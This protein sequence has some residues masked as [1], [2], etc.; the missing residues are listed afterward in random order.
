MTNIV[1][2]YRIS[3]VSQLEGHGLEA[4]QSRC[5]DYCRSKGYQVLEEFSDVYSGKGDY[6]ERPGF[7][8]MMEYIAANNVD[9]IVADDNK[10]ISRDLLGYLNL[11]KVLEKYNTRIECL[12]ANFE[13]T[14]EGRFV[15]NILAATAELEREQNRRQVINKMAERKKKGCWV[16]S[17]PFGFKIVNDA[18]HGKVLEPISSKYTRLI[19]KAFTFYSNDK[20]KTIR[21]VVNFLESNNLEKSNGGFL[22]YNAV[23]NMLSSIVY[24]GYNVVDGKKYKTVHSPIVSIELFEEVQSKLY[25]KG[26]IL[27]ERIQNARR[28]HKNLQDEYELSGVLKCYECHSNMYGR[29]AKKIYPYYQCTNK[30]CRIKNKCIGQKKSEY[31]A[32]L[33]LYIGDLSTSALIVHQK[34]TLELIIS[35]MAVEREK[36][37]AQIQEIEAKICMA[38]SPKVMGILEKKILELE[39]WIKE[40]NQLKNN[41]TLRKQ[42]WIKI[43]K[44]TKVASTLQQVYK[45]ANKKTR[46]KLLKWLFPHGVELKNGEVG[47]K[48]LVASKA[49]QG[50][51]KQQH[52]VAE[53]INFLLVDPSGLEPLTSCVQSRRS[54]Q[55]S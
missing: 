31:D 14:E 25:D 19:Q 16:T 50:V 2:Y 45:T 42:G 54:S 33:A 48:K 35:N 30:K 6:K 5:R 34:K 41:D 38:E 53:L 22:K 20:L 21:D 37:V 17:A 3:S 27:S 32:Y 40:Y 47:W 15:Q 36:K 18:A 1:N 51:K 4:Q 13:D 8:K 29:Y 23:R 24:A 49:S 55:M 9:I 12:N 7:V 26:R 10:R 46:K 52:S 39:K 28:S 44:F 43:S 11:K